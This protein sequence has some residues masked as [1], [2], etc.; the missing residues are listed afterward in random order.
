MSFENT[1]LNIINIRNTPHNKKVR[2]E[3]PE[4]FKGMSAPIFSE[5][6]I[7]NYKDT[8]QTIFWINPGLTWYNALVLRNPTNVVLVGKWREGF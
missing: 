1:G 2:S 4:Y 8:R 3:I 7:M 5:F 6:R